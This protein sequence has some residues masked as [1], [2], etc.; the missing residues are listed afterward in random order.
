MKPMFLYVVCVR[1]VLPLAQV[2]L[3]NDI[4]LPSPLADLL[5]E[6]H[7][8]VVGAGIDFLLVRHFENFEVL[9][10]QVQLGSVF[11]TIV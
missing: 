4:G 6:F 2:R 1:A 5:E 8:R 9:F 11:T 7:H 10:E 3:T